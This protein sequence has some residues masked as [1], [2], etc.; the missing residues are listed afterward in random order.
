MIVRYL[1]IKIVVAKMLKL[2]WGIGTTSPSSKVRG[3]HRENSK[4]NYSQGFHAQ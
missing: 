4:M 3:K 2:K 1:K